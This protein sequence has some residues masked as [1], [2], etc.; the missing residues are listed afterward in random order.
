M[1]EKLKNK[2]VV[3]TIIGIVSVLLVAAAVTY[4]YWLVTKTQQGENVVSSGCLDIDLV[5]SGDITLQDQ[6][7]I[8]DEDGMKLTPYEFTITNK[9]N[10]SVD[11]FVNLES[12]AIEGETIN[13]DALKVSLND[14]VSVLGSN[15]EEEPTIEGAFT[16]HRLMQGTLAK[17][18]S[19]GASINYNLRIWIAEDAPISEMNKEFKSKISVTVGQGIT[20]TLKEGTLAYNI[21]SKY[22]E[23]NSITTINSEWSETEWSSPV[24]ESMS[25]NS[26]YYWGTELI[27]DKSLGRYTLGGTITE[28]TVEECRNGQK[29]DGTAINCG[30][31]TL[32]YY[33]DEDLFGNMDAP[34]Y[35]TK[36]MTV[37]Y[38]VTS[39]TSSQTDSSYSTYVT[40]QK[41]QA[42]TNA[43]KTSTSTAGLYK[44]QDD[45]SDSYY[46]RGNIKNNYVEFGIMEDAEYT[47]IKDRY[48]ILLDVESSCGKHG[49]CYESEAACEANKEEFLAEHPEY[50]PDYAWCGQY[51]TVTETKKEDAPMYWR[52]VRINGD[53]SIRLV[54][55]GYS[56]VENGVSHT[57]TL[58]VESTI[59][60][61]PSN[62]PKYA[63]YTY[64]DGTGN[65]VDSII[66]SSL[67]EW[68]NS[69][70]KPNYEKYIADTVFCNDLSGYQRKSGNFGYYN[71]IRRLDA[72][73]P[74]LTCENEKDRYTVNSDKGNGYLSN[75]I[76]L[77][78]A[79]EV[80]LAGISNTD[81]IYS[82][83]SFWTMTP[84]AY[85]SL[86]EVLMYYYSS[87]YKSLS[88][89][90]SY[91]TVPKVR[92][93]INLKA[94]VAFTGDGSY[95][96]PYKIVIE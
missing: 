96:T 40:A 33:V 4:A 57:A 82:G 83:E 30:I 45:L 12:L 1:K 24:A 31:Y 10:T 8:S 21:V 87:E 46:F 53:G 72:F 94:D 3:Y 90:S 78:T 26:E 16:S 95:E 47:E 93:V 13:A 89:T 81:Y 5:G 52:I 38:K 29:S 36:S 80:L 32:R 55:D 34:Y 65:Q 70:L 76:G 18:G 84:A 91:Y 23:E 19:E 66:K 43:F 37:A 54:Y 69:Y 88:Y 41:R 75:P 64:D 49:V 39:L 63:G 86:E 9:C 6:F 62:N 25:K 7:P 68:Y 2:K 79:D 77:L 74:S 51:D 58:D 27:F 61:K 73:N 20:N 67:D 50:D 28:A 56:K 48:H 35:D 11:Y 92:P 15:Y 59:Y 85:D 17:K 14:K 42:D 60:N 44:T 71:S 22:G